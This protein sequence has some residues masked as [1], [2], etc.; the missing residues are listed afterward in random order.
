MILIMV[1]LE[2][3]IRLTEILIITYTTGIDDHHSF[4]L[5]S[6]IEKLDRMRREKAHDHSSITSITKKVNYANPSCRNAD[7]YRR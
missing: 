4:F 5:L 1:G 3:K 7:N 6:T 2:N